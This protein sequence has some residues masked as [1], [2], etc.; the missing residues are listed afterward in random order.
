MINKLPGGLPRGGRLRRSL[1][2]RLEG[3]IGSG[4]AKKSICG[5]VA[6]VIECA[7]D[8]IPVEPGPEITYRGRVLR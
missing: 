2:A 1:I 7:L 3:D 4:T 5:G 8:G 6:L